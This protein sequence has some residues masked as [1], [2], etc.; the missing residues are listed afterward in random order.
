MAEPTL[1]DVFGAN[2]S[3]SSTTLT[4]SKADLAAAGLTASSDNKAESLLAALILLAK[5]ALTATNFAANSDQSITI[6]N[7][8]N[9]IVQRDNG[10]GNFSEYRQ[11]QYN[12]NAHKLD[13]VALDPDEL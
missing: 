7:G 4:I 11:F 13:N 9:S 5:D 2:A 12:F 3:Q 8:F 1:A 10:D 6:T